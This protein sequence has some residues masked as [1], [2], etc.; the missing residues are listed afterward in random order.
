MTIGFRALNWTSRETYKAGEIN[1][2]ETTPLT[3][4]ETRHD[5]LAHGDLLRASLYGLLCVEHSNIHHARVKTKLVIVSQNGTPSC[6]LIEKPLQSTA[7]I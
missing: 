2:V 3:R 6:M 7:E 1:S 5:F 4:T